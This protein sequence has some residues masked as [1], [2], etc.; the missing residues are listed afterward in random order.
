VASCGNCGGENPAGHR[1]CGQCGN[2]LA[3]V[4]ASCGR[5]SQPGERFC[6]ECGAPLSEAAAPAAVSEA[7]VAERRLVSVLFADL[8]GFTTLSESRDAEEVRDLLSRYFESCRRLI[9]LYGGTVEKFIGDAVM[10]VWGA[11]TAQEDDAE[12]AVRAALDLVAM[13]SALGQELG[14]PDLQARAGV[15][16]GDAAVTL[17]A[18]GQGMVA[19]DL[20][21]SASRIQ[22]VAEPGSVFVGDRT[23]RASE[24]AIA[25]DDAGIHELKGKA[26]PVQ[27]FRAL[28]VTGARGG[29]LKSEG[30]EPPF[31]GRDRE[32]RL[33]KE[34][35]LSSAEEK[36]TQLVSIV[37]IAGIGKS[38]LS[39]EFEKYVDGLIQD[40]WWHRGRCLAYGD[41]VAYWALAE[42]VRMRCG[43][44]ED[45]DPQSA[46][47]KLRA[48]LGEHIA[49][50]DERQWVEPRLAHLLALEGAAT[51]DEENLFSAWR[52]LFER[53]AEQSPTILVF[54]DMQWA[55]AGLLDFLE[56]LLEWSHS[57]P[58]FVLVLAR[59]EL[60]DKRPLWGTGRRGFNSLYLEP[61]P[62]KAMSDL[63]AGLVPGLSDE[64]RARI[65]ERAEGIPLYA[66]ETVRMLLDRGLL[67]REGDAYRPIGPIDTLEV[68]ETLQALIAARL[69]SLAPRERSLLQDAAV[70]GKV[71]T[72][73]GLTALTGMPDAELEPLLSALVRKEML[74]IQADPRSPER[75]Q[76]SFLQDLVKHVAY[77]TISRRE[78]KKKHLATADFLLTFLTT[79]EDEAIEVVAS[80]YLDA[81]AAAPDDPDAEEIRS[82]ACATLIRAAE[83]AASLAANSEA[84]RAY[85]R[86]LGLTDD[87]LAQAEV[88]ERAGAAAAIGARAD[89]AS[90]H[91]ERSIALFD[92][93]GATHPAARVS[94]RLAEIQWD[95][96]RLEDGLELMERSLD[97]LLEEEPDADVA[98]L[99]AQVGR[100]RFFSGDAKLAAERIETALELAE[101]LALPEVLSQALNTKAL[102]LA[103]K[104]RR[105]EGSVL[106]R[107]ALEVA[108]E[109][110]KPSAALRAF[111]NVADVVSTCGD[112][113]EEGVATVRQGLAYARKVGN[114][115][116]ELA[117]LGYGYPFYAAG[118]WDD[119]LAMRD[120]LPSED[121]TRA[122][123]AYGAALGCAVPVYVHRGRLDEAEKMVD[124]LSELER[125]ADVQERCQYGCAA[126]HILLAQGDH[127]RALHHAEA[128]FEGRDS[129]GVVADP[130]KEAFALAVQA[131]LEL[132]R[133]DKAD[134]LLGIVERLPRGFRPLFLDAHVARFRA[135]IAARTGATED[136]ERLFK[137][138]GGRFHELAIPFHLAVTRLEHAEWLAE[139]GRA[140]DARPL[141][142]EAR[143]I[144]E[145]LDARPW[146]DRL[147][148]VQTGDRT[149]VTA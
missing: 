48:A 137:G 93:A 102:I 57:L 62:E 65:L 7:P 50:P 90:G 96:G 127:A 142:A 36:K 30:L 92:A 61:L 130:V 47:E 13:V 144:F 46:R 101:A 38:R 74:S 53:L 23:R 66:V 3:V 109:H 75:G 6:G 103:T 31:V 88:H 28:R 111:F 8:V 2:A 84:Q 121:W 99:A 116:W 5:P 4:C 54:E 78:R 110:D 77:H 82:K 119:V 42:M 76:Y 72:K 37:G 58:L 14:A 35:F 94:A 89:E 83:R 118:A 114:R 43:I 104:G 87:P 107:Y 91:F 63:L 60:G 149:E 133:L 49:D 9:A 51:G 128:A 86:A 44:A 105:D 132:D 59:P 139:Q 134:E 45:E 79:E 98:A 148:R 126:A 21:N 120:E 1:F 131:A 16:T 112:R 143:E 95:R 20:V 70:L 122:R 146:L 34:L 108:L 80:H 24:A 135:R 115:W 32:L 41:G 145:R 25:Y 68:P 15:L 129:L 33:V 69:D 52:I 56:Y 136:A 40:F 29:A 18:E 123:L 117:F 12:R 27:L 71:F 141:L 19:G 124:A 26:E 67:A 39:W 11:P 73:H 17:G 55:D 81:Y 97:V 106:L 10:A 125:S 140:D 113:Y 147:E 64:P 138:A 100:F 85:E 22:S